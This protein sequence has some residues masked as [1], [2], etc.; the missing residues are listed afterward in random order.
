MINL[1][2]RHQTFQINT[3]EFPCVIR[4]LASTQFPDELRCLRNFSFTYLGV[5]SIQKITGKKFNKN[6]RTKGESNNIM[7]NS[8]LLCGLCNKADFKTMVDGSFAS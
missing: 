4:F 2:L 8:N 3:T 7:P 5:S 6:G 1:K